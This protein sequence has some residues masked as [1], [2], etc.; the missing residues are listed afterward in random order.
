[1]SVHFLKKPDEKVK[2]ASDKE[3]TKPNVLYFT[4]EDMQNF[5]ID[6]IYI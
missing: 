3:L 1:M 2:I 5:S 6:N 4:R